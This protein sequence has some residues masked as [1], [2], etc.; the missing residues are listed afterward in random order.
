MNWSRAARDILV[1]AA[2]GAAF[3]L[4]IGLL[5]QA[6]DVDINPFAPIALGIFLGAMASISRQG[7][8][9]DDS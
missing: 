4:I 8:W 1:F 2:V 5:F 6:I 7:S 3:G 9:S